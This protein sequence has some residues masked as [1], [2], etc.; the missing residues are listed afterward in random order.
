[1]ADCRK[2]PS[3]SNCQLT[4]IGPEED[5]LDAAVDHAVNKHGHERTAELREQIRSMLE[6]APKEM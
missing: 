1:M 4:I 2:M 5:L 3:E 6:D